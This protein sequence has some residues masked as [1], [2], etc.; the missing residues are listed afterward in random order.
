MVGAVLGAC[1]IALVIWKQR[2]TKRLQIN[3]AYNKSHSV[4]R[5]GSSYGDQVSGDQLIMTKEQEAGTHR[6]HLSNPG[7]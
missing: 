3:Q 7:P 6:V 4:S 1:M 5:K 2:D